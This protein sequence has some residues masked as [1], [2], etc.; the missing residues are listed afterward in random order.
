VASGVHTLAR[1]VKEQHAALFHRTAAAAG[2]GLD[3]VR[4]HKGVRVE[5]PVR[6][7]I[8]VLDA[9]SRP[10]GRPWGSVLFAMRLTD[11]DGD[12]LFSA[13]NRVLIWRRSTAIGGPAAA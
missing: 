4:F 6:G 5:R 2:Q 9:R 11:E 7:E 3:A 1:V 8:E 10:G 12:L 13:Q